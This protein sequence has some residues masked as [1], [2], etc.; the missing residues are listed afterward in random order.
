MNREYVAKVLK[1]EDELAKE[2]LL[3]DGSRVLVR[4]IESWL[5]APESLHVVDVREG[6]IFVSYR[7]I[8]A[9]RHVQPNGR[10][11]KGSRKR[12]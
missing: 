7:N 8:T 6:S 10:G 9:I 11:K 5:A 4:G 2:L 12:R 3:N 1:E